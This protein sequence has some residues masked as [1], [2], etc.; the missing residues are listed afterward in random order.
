MNLEAEVYGLAAE[1]LAHHVMFA[2]LCRGLVASSPQLADLVGQ[3]FDKTIESL[4]QI[5]IKQGAQSP[6]EHTLKALKIVE[7]LRS[8]VIGDPRH[9]N[10]GV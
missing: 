7:E 2:K 10:H 6:P 9:P 3:M 8:S 4:E 5:A 1:S